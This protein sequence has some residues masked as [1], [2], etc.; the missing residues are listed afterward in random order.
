MRD[1]DCIATS[2]IFV[3]VLLPPSTNAAETHG[4]CVGDTPLGEEP[5]GDVETSRD[6]ECR[7]RVGTA[8]ATASLL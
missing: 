8:A 6:D 7:N 1:P 3:E 4:A 2:F 5:L